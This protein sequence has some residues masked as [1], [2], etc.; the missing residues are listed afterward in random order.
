M[1]SNTSLAK[2]LL[3]TFLS[4]SILVLG[5]VFYGHFVMYSESKVSVDSLSLGQGNSQN[6]VVAL[7]RWKKQQERNGGLENLNVGLGYS[8]AYSIENTCLLY[9]SDAADE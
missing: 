1:K 4:I 8:R 3:P 6:L 9:T 7:E 2:I 5:V